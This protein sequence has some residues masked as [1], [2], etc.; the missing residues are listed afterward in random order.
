MTITQ[1]VIEAQK[2][3]RAAFGALYESMAGDLYRMALYT[4][5][6]P[7]DAEDAVAETFAEAWKGLKNLREPEAFRSWMFRILSF[8]CKRKIG[9]YVAQRREIAAMLGLPQGTVSS[10]LSRTLKKLRRQ[11]QENGKEAEK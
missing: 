9:R 6:N 3:S 8:R 4:L 10:K 5:G 1:Q 7:Q 11:L 2:G